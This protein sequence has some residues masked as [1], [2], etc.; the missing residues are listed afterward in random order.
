LSAPSERPSII[1]VVVEEARFAP[2]TSFDLFVQRE[3]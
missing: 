3:L 1:D 2:L